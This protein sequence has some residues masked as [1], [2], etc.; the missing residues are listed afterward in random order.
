MYDNELNRRD[1]S[2]VKMSSD[3]KAGAFCFLQAPS[4]PSLFTLTLAIMKTDA[5]T[6]EKRKYVRRENFIVQAC[7]EYSTAVEKKR[8]ECEDALSGLL[9]GGVA[10]AIK[11]TPPNF[12]K[13][14][15]TPVISKIAEILPGHDVSIPDRDGIEP[16]R[17]SNFPVLVDGKPVAGI[18][19]GGPNSRHLNFTL[20][21]SGKAWGLPLKIDSADKFKTVMRIL[22]EVHGFNI[23]GNDAEQ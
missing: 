23:T 4:G 22:I 9:T 8:K 14:V 19:Y 7:R 6:T 16:D 21:A 12:I 13:I 5:T 18:G 2:T 20:Y 15:F 17:Y 10:G 11:I 1:F 3:S